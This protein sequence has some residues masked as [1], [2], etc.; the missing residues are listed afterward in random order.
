MPF[1]ESVIV[2]RQDM[3]PNHVENLVKDYTDTIK[4]YEGQV[5]KTEFC[6]LRSLAY[7][8]K[9]NKK[10]HYV[11]L[12]VAV[13]SDGLV[14]ME[15]QMAINEDIL[16]YLSTKVDKLDNTPSSLMQQKSYRDTF[17]PSSEEDF[18]SPVL[19]NDASKQPG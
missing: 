14:E 12:N 4:K 18:E 15:R 3:S 10:G 13:K 7:P 2:F 17:R 5:I 9:K 19:N 8:I 1:Y 16:R 6:G 11:L